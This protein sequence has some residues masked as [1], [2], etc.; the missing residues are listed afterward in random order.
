[1]IRLLKWARNRIRDMLEAD[2]KNA[3]NGVIKGIFLM[4]RIGFCDRMND[5]FRL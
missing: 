5:E 2:K 3:F 1:M 4:R